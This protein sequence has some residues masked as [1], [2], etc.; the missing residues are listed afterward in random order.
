MRKRILAEIPRVSA[1]SPWLTTADVARML[2]LTPRGVRWLA[3]EGRLASQRTHSGQLLFRTPDV[4]RFAEKRMQVRL[5]GPP[6]R[7]RPGHAEPHQLSLVFGASL[8]VVGGR[9]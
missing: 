5:V 3:T 4:Q 7:M 2:D 1:P 8:R 9:G 6:R